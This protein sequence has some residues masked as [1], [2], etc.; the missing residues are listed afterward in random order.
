MGGQ[1]NLGLARQIGVAPPEVSVRDQI[2][3]AVQRL[4]PAGFAALP[5]ATARAGT[6]GRRRCYM[7]SNAPAVISTTAGR[8]NR[9]DNTGRQARGLVPPE[10][11][12]VSVMAGS[13]LV[14]ETVTRMLSK[15]SGLSEI[16]AFIE[17]QPLAEEHKAALW[18]WAWAKQSLTLP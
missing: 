17:R 3:T 2:T 11:D 12:G 14:Q 9:A 7:H 4:I 18:L 5:G 15:G 10:H 6:V 8:G 16:E 1:D 13:E